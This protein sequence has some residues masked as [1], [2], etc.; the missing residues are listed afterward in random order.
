MKKIIL[1]LSLVIFYLPIY[2]QNTQVDSLES[3]LINHLKTD[4]VKI[5]L[6]NTIAE[7]SLTIDLSK[8]LQYATLADSLSDVLNYK[9][10]KAL[11]LRIIGNYYA[12]KHNHTQALS[13]Y[14]QALEISKDIDNK[15]DI[16][17]LYNYSGNIYLMQGDY[18][19]AMEY[20]KKALVVFKEINDKIGISGVYN[21]FA[22]IYY[23]EGDYPRTLE[24][25]QKALKVFEELNNKTGISGSYNNIG[26]VYDE[27]GNYTKA[28]EYYK[29]ALAI[30]EDLGD[31][32]GISDT[33]TNIGN[34]YYTKIDYDN[35]LN[36]FQKAAEINKEI[37]DKNGISISYLNI[38][39]VY[40]AQHKYSESIDYFQKSIKIAKEKHFQGL[41][42]L[43]YTELCKVYFALE[44]YKLAIQYGEKG[45]NL[46]H[47]LGEKENIK[48]ASHILSKCYAAKSDFQKAYRFHL[49]YKNQSDSLFNENNIQEITNLENQYAFEKEKEGMAA[50]QAKKDAVQAEELKS[51]KIVRNSFIAGF[52]LM[53]VIAIFIF[54]N[55]AIKRKANL[56]L[57]KQ[58][59]EIEQQSDELKS[60]NDKLIEL[61]EFKQG[62]TSMIVHDLKNPLNGIINVSDTDSPKNQLIKVKQAGKQMLNM[63]L[64]I[65]DVQKYE[66]HR[67]TINK[68][69]A[70][71]YELSQ[72]AIKDV[73][74]LAVRK[75]ITIQNNI[76]ISTY[77]KVDS[78][79]IERVF[80]NL[81]TNAIKYTPNNGFI[82]LRAVES[83]KGAIK[84]EVRDTGKGI[85]SDKLHLVF[86]KFGQVAAKKSGGIRS[87]GLG[88]T[89]C[90]MAVEAHGQEIGVKSELDQGTTF[91]FTLETSDKPKHE[92]QTV[93]EKIHTTIDYQL[94]AAEKQLLS[95][96]VKQLKQIEIY[97]M[98]DILKLLKK[99]DDSE[100]TNIALWKQD[101][102][103][104]I[105]SG[106]TER[107]NEL[108]NL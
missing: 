66:E 80:I 69:P 9:K 24:Y 22:N 6:L 102:Q 7:K 8:T 97:R 84:I 60:A 46:A 15:T 75:N 93:T 5:N 20:Y 43:N 81:L 1:Y 23:M 103:N 25:M 104:T 63:V 78:E 4:T 56:L 107:Y 29:K 101:I 96:F 72:T 35:A 108:L 98:F 30:R 67:M 88:L 42:T 99:I 28:L 64:N 19:K 83:I 77:A 41:I 105:S 36:Y 76:D 92:N 70:S 79:I 52:I 17:Y 57:A 13:H 44:N 32:Y 47:D 27:Q 94:T 54:K 45:Y 11:S 62:M 74:F 50:K 3:L 85:P 34:I 61:D 31:K 51:Q 65:L 26:V 38:G 2:S 106:N 58:K 12:Y 95:P 10:G 90:K 55:L 14:Q 89:F 71:L 39:M 73:T 48:E 86:T 68:T 16:S 21:N 18:P 37:D 49:E 82:T 100:N 59:Q 87:T 53:I 40:L 91:W 33:Y